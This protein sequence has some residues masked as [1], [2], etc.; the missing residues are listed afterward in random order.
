MCG[1]LTYLDGSLELEED[2]LGDEDLT[3]LGAQIADLG[4]KQLDLLAGAAAPD[5]E[6]AVD[7]GVEVNLVLVRHVSMCH[8]PRSMARRVRYACG[9]VHPRRRRTV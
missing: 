9:V 2:G 1:S 5:L 6:E 7:D 4:L 8:L 3:S